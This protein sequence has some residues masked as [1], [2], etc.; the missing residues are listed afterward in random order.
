MA[1]IG[2]LQDTFEDHTINWIDISD[3]EVIVANNELYNDSFVGLGSKNTY[4]IKDSAA[5]LEVSSE[6]VDDGASNFSYWVE[7][8]L[9]NATEFYQIYLYTSGVVEGFSDSTLNNEWLYLSPGLIR[10]IRIRESEGRVYFEYSEDGHIFTSILDEASGDTED[11]SVDIFVYGGNEYITQRLVS[12]NIPP[13]P[14]TDKKI[15]Y[16]Y[17]DSS[18]NRASIDNVNDY[19]LTEEINAAGSA[20]QLKVPVD[21]LTSNSALE[22]VQIIDE[23]G[24][25]L[26]TESALDII[27]SSEITLDG[28]PQLNNSIEIKEYSS[29]YLSGKTI[30]TG[31]ALAYEYD[32][33][34]GNMLIDCVSNGAKLDKEILNIGSVATHIDNWTGLLSYYSVLIRGNASSTSRSAIAQ[35]FT[36]DSNVK[37]LS[38]DDVYF[39][40]YGQYGYFLG[41]NT[42]ELVLKLYE[43]TPGSSSTLLASS[44]NNY[45]GSYQHTTLFTFT[46]DQS[47]DL[48]TGTNYYFTIEALKTGVTADVYTVGVRATET[49]SYANGSMYE[50]VANSGWSDLGFDMMFKLVVYE[51][52]IDANVFNSTDPSDM[53][54]DIIGS[55]SDLGMIISSDSSTVKNT[56]TTVSYTF[57]YSTIYEALKKCIELAPAG[58]W[59]Y[60]DSSTNMFYY[61]SKPEQIHTYLENSKVQDFKLRRSLE[62]VINTQ[63]IVGGEVAGEN[64]LVKSQNNLSIAKYGRWSETKTDNRITDETSAALIG[65]GIVDEYAEPRFSAQVVI[66][67]KDYDIT[68]MKPGQLIGFNN[69][70]TIIDNLRLQIMSIEKTR[71]YARL[72]LEILPPTQAKRIE[73]LRR[74]LLVS[75]TENNPS[76]STA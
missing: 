8:T 68:S 4:S 47:V 32:L 14:A 16:E 52:T 76:I 70:N 31:F 59:F 19:M 40:V 28:I 15:V 18:G 74:N 51:S 22:E 9:E 53:V 39:D 36:V 58:W 69:F 67:A 33:K 60:F 23:N 5:T 46:L 42:N 12:F 35:T 55:A 63:Y 62:N 27:A 38:I 57:K 24:D 29:R 48:T 17:I 26:I 20:L 30:F 45:V 65:E 73:D 37:A 50:Y 10:Y 61:Q 21:L 56:N 72:Q 1:K 44:Y 54:L 6:L 3:P 75:D 66:S 41:Y 49:S 11:F 13:E 43:G 7:I 71:D 25:Q 34:A 64:L 2:S